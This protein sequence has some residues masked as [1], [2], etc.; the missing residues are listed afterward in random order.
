MTDRI[1]YEVEG[2]ARIE[3]TMTSAAHDLG[4]FTD[5]NQRV[6]ALVSAAAKGNAPRLSG[7]LAASLDGDGTPDEVTVGSD[8]IYAGVQ[9][10]GWAARHIRPRH[11]IHDAY[12]QTT[13]E[14]EALYA[15]RIDDVLAQVK[16]Q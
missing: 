15:Q 1:R 6:A 13:A 12:D 8:V 2:A 4:D 3:A 7:R 9:E 14:A 11:Y 5:T 10:Y 16:G